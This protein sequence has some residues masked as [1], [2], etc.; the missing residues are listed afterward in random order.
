MS[1]SPEL[2]A[3]PRRSLRLKHVHGY[4]CA[5]RRRVH[6]LACSLA[7]KAGWWVAIG[8]AVEACRGA[9]KVFAAPAGQPLGIGLGKRRVLLCPI[10]T[11]RQRLVD[12]HVLG[13]ADDLNYIKLPPAN[14]GAGTVGGR[15]RSED[16][17]AIDFV[18]ALQTRCQI[19]SVAHHRIVEALLRADITDN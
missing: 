12:P 7:E 5:G 1:L 16:A 18:G 9:G 15:L 3:R 11:Q 14:A 13:L 4:P 6:K 8:E 2:V 17:G 19:G 10:G